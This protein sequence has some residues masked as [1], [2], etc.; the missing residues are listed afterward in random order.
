MRGHKDD[1]DLHKTN[2]CESIVNHDGNF[3]VLLLYRIDG[4]DSVLENHIKTAGKNV[5]YISK[6][7]TN[8]LI[9]CCGNGILDVIL[10]WIK[11]VTFYCII[12]DE[13]AVSLWNMFYIY[14]NLVYQKIYFRKYNKGKFV[15]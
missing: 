7:S 4:W 15:L 8:K 3:W 9:Q 11:L 2:V 10:Q 14:H 12:F 6:T 5:T 13:T 1:G